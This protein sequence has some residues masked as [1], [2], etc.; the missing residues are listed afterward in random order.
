MEEELEFANLLGT[1]NGL[2]PSQFAD[3]R[4]WTLKNLGENDT[5]SLN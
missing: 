4:I 1:I 5:K 2:I 3:K